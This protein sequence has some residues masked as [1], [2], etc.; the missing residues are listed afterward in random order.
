MMQ[1]IQF[2]SWRYNQVHS[3]SYHALSN[4]TVSYVV[5]RELGLC[6]QRLNVQRFGYNHDAAQILLSLVVFRQGY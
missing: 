1:N 2:L 4:L 6:K 3:T 5:P